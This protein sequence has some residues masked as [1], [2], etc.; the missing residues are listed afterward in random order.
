MVYL[1]VSD[2]GCLQVQLLSFLHFM[3]KMMSYLFHFLQLWMKSMFPQH[4]YK[5]ILG[6]DVFFSLA[7]TH[8]K[9]MG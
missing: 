1:Y 4:V 6:Y 9:I 7:L 5:M 3:V 8:L 2:H